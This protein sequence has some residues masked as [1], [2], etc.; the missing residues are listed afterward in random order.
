M[1]VYK[2]K[3]RG[4]WFYQITHKGK[5]YKKR[6][7]KTKKE[8]Q[9]AEYLRVIELQENKE[10]NKTDT[11]L[12]DTVYHAYFDDLKRKIKPASYYKSKMTADKHI[13]PV[14]KGKNFEK[15]ETIDVINFRNYLIDNF[16]VRYARNIYSRVNAIFKYGAVFGSKHNPCILAGPISTRKQKNEMDYWTFEEFKQFINV[17]DD[18]V[19]YTLFMTLYYMGIRKGEAQALQWTDIDFKNSRMTIDKTYYRRYNRRKDEPSWGIGTPKTKSSTRTISMPKVLKEALLYYYDYCKQFDGFSDESF[20]FGVVKPIPN[21]TMERWF[22]KYIKK[23][24]VKEIRIHDLRHC[25]ASLLISQGVDILTISRRLGH[26][27]PSETLNTYGHMFPI[28]DQEAASILD[29]IS[30]KSAIKVPQFK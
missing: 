27:N 9:H 23:A 16:S 11:L 12:Y 10:E 5:K 26:A 18:I 3:K 4:T 7:F 28:K 21:T 17:V 6:G 15:I 20:V 22:K 30:L 19:Y 24:G 14:F 29:K 2:D 8:A 13:L 1:P 25:N